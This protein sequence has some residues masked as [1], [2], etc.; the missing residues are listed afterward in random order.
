MGLGYILEAKPS[1]KL[2]EGRK[3]RDKRDSHVSGLS[4][5]VDNTVFT[6]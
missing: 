1:G 2:V 6:E 5:W 4:N 3:R